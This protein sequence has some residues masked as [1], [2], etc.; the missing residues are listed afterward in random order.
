MSARRVV[1]LLAPIVVAA[2]LGPLVVG[3]AV[4][5]FALGRSLFDPIELLPLADWWGLLVFYVIMTYFI[6]GP[7]AL[8]SGVLV[9]L[10]MIRRLPS[11]L[12]VNAA[13]VI[14]TAVFM[15]VAALGVLGPVEE[16]NGR[17]NFW[18]TLVFA[19]VAANVCWLL[20]RRFARKAA[21][22]AK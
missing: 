1:H 2:V 15:G 14:A 16:T 21:R 20:L 18:F 13:A 17:S 22:V 12:I 9:S 7:I 10:W 3:L 19:V 6:G 4:W 5:L 8:L 11:A